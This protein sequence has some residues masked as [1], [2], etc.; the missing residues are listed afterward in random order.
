VNLVEPD[1]PTNYSWYVWHDLPGLASIC[2]IG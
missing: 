2:P 1:G